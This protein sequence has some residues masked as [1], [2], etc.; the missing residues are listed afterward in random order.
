MARRAFVATC[1]LVIAAALPAPALALSGASSSGN[2][3]IAQYVTPAKCPPNTHFDPATHLCDPDQGP[4]GFISYA[5]LT[6]ASKGTLPFTGYLL[7]SV[8]GVALV[9]LASGLVLHRLAR[10]GIA[11]DSSGPLS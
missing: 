6:T 9:L 5:S 4:A 8:S 11:E 7:L 3:S 2:A 1:A 10:R